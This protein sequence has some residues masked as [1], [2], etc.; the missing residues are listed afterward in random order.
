MNFSNFT[1]LY[2]SLVKLEQTDVPKLQDDVS[3][4]TKSNSTFESTK[5]KLTTRLSKAE[6]S[7]QK[8]MEMA[9]T[10]ENKICLLTT[11]LS[12]VESQLRL[13]VWAATKHTDPS[14]INSS[15]LLGSPGGFGSSQS[16]AASPT[17]HSVFKNPLQ[18]FSPGNLV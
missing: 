12:E 4:V 3:K 7:H 11:R 13:L 10:S 15:E 5:R 16:S 1:R 18:G 14:T 17:R 2:D 6:Q 9:A 8:L